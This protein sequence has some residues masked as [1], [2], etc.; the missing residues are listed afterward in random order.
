MQSQSMAPYSLM[1]CAFF[2]CAQAVREIMERVNK[3]VKILTAGKALPRDFAVFMDP[4][5][6]LTEPYAPAFTVAR[7]AP[8]HPAHAA[9]A[10]FEQ[11]RAAAM[12]SPDAA[13]AAAPNVQ[14]EAD[15]GAPQ[16]VINLPFGGT[17]E[18]R[19]FG[20]LPEIVFAYPVVA[21]P[22][23]IPDDP[24]LAAVLRESAQE[25][26]DDEITKVRM[27]AQ[28]YVILSQELLRVRTPTM[29]TSTQASDVKRSL[30][31]H[32]AQH[33][34]LLH[35]WLPGRWNRPECCVALV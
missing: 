25:E 18:K 3:G 12:A 19:P 26:L 20:A 13:P 23:D 15:A 21:V 17:G 2:T 29:H 27:A 8:D 7:I 10:A 5:Q 35:V 24:E 6:P 33:P 28:V 16:L 14:P 30:C 1:V 31:N 11:Q 4:Q 32:E 34:K 22:T 9:L